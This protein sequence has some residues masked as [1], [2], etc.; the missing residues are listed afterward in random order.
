M[1]CK[2][3][4][5]ITAEMFYQFP[6]MKKHPENQEERLWNISSLTLMTFYTHNIMIMALNKTI[7]FKYAQEDAD[8]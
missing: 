6:P 1:D 2:Y 8:E 4:K 7:C 5:W 3:K